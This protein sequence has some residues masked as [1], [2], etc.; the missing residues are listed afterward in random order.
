MPMLIA[1]VAFPISGVAIHALAQGGWDL[2]LLSRAL[3]GIP[4]A[5]ALYLAHPREHALRIRKA[6]LLRSTSAVVFLALL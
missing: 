1:S 5:F 3:F 6:I 2:A 4:F